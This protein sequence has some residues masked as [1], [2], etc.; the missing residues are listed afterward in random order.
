MPAQLNHTIVAA[1]DA[2]S[3]AAWLADLLDLP[4]PTT[5]VHFE[6]VM[7]ANGVTLD[8]L[9]CDDAF[10]V[11]HYAFL[12]TE[13]EFDDIFERIVARDIAYWADPACERAGQINH[14]DGGR[15]VYFKNADGHV[16]EMITR[17]YGS[18]PR[19]RSS[20]PPSG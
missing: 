19:P 18:G 15:G 10:E 14:N 12:V 7:T 3:A 8:F 11:Q 16:L 4:P 6:C 5:F 2:R 13:R 20:F 17:P 9:R 1:K